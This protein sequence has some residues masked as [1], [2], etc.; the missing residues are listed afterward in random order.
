[1]I[2]VF[3]MYIPPRVGNNEYNWG[4]MPVVF[5]SVQNREKISEI[6]SKVGAVHANWG[7]CRTWI[8][9]FLRFSNLCDASW[10][11]SGPPLIGTPLVSNNSVLIREVSFGERED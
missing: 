8:Q 3:L 11:Y 5:Y 1:M 6:V 7:F 10:R 2:M 4:I 9:T